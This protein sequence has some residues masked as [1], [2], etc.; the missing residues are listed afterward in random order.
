VPICAKTA[1][2]SVLLILKKENKE[3]FKLLAKYM[4]GKIKL[5]KLNKSMLVKEYDNLWVN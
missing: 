1:I 4:D 5:E 3:S 2:N